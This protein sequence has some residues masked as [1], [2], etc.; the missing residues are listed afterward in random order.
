MKSAKS[1]LV[2]LF[3]ATFFIGCNKS[4]PEAAPIPPPAVA[5]PPRPAS[6]RGTPA[7]TAPDSGP[8]S[9]PGEEPSLAEL[10]RALNA[11]TIGLLKEPA[12]LEDLVKEGF[13]KRVP[14]AP[15]GKKFVL[16]AKKS[17]VL[18]VDK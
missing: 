7:T 13:I 12:T 17:A 8:P 14:A 16:N 4:K 2:L 15:P 3:V 9:T 1:A 10:H 6:S 18:I 11:Y 5:P